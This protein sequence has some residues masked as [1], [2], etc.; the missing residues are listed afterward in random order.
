MNN[1]AR[2]ASQQAHLIREENR[3]VIYDGI[4]YVRTLDSKVQTWAKEGENT[5][6][7]SKELIEA[8]RHTDVSLDVTP[9]DFKYPFRSFVIE[10]EVPLFD[11]TTFNM[12]ED[13]QVVR[14]VASILY[15][16]ADLILESGNVSIV[17]IDG[18]IQERPDWDH[19]LNAFFPSGIYGMENIMLYMRGNETIQSSIDTRKGGSVILPVSK[20][21]AHNII[22][23][24]YNSVLYINDPSRN[25]SETEERG[26]RKMKMSGR[27][28]HRSQ[29]RFLKPPK[30]YKPLY[31]ASGKT[32][33]KHFIVRGH[34]RNQACGEKRAS[35]KMTWIQPYWKGPQM[36][37]IISRPYVI[38]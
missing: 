18:S 24:F 7:L 23:I 10:G 29:Y 34:W 26:S 28:P 4:Y 6:I 1:F 36:S 17:G 33:D 2:R 37:E 27:E 12:E 15:I 32:L 31:A 9:N 11:T 16:S 8:F 13:K 20:E 22:N 5:F 14:S 38:A 19:S 35:R 30:L 21:D 25:I 3:Q